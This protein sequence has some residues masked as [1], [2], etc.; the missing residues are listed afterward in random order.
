VYIHEQV[1]A[2]SDERREEIF[3]NIRM[4]NA[5]QGEN[6]CQIEYQMIKH[7]FFSAKLNVGLPTS[8]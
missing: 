6:A 8:F 2:I 7:R 4:P 1:R 3:T 5:R